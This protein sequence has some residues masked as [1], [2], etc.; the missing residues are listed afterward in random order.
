M[1]ALVAIGSS[2][3]IAA[4]CEWGPTGL[5]I[6]DNISWDEWVSLGFLLARLHGAIQWLAGDWWIWGER[7][8]GE[9]AAAASSLGIDPGTLSQYAWV[10]GRVK[11]YTRVQGLSW[12]YHREIAPLSDEE[13]GEWL[14]KAMPEPGRDKPSLTVR[15]LHRELHPEEPAEPVV[16]ALVTTEAPDL[17]A[18]IRALIQP[19]IDREDIHPVEGGRWYS[20]VAGDSLAEVL[21]DIYALVTP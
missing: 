11:P 4:R 7:H 16:S 15:E 3:S 14:S 10:A 18:R 2:D 13:Q 9:R 12:T 19:L 21:S 17:A 8:Y 1:D 5:G 6:P 20:R